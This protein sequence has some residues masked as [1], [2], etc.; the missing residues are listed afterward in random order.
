MSADAILDAMTAHAQAV[1]QE[2]EALIGRPAGA[3]ARLTEAMR[4]AALGGGKRLRPFLVHAV[5]SIGTA[6]RR[7]VLRGGAAI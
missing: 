6:D 1:E 3:T 4:H 2:L 5:A 7:A